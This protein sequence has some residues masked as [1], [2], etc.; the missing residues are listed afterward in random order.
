ML[1]KPSEILVGQRWHYINPA[2]GR[3]FIHTITRIDTNGYWCYSDLNRDFLGGHLIVKELLGHEQGS[4]YWTYLGFS[5]EQNKSN[6]DGCICNKCA[7]FVP[8]AQPNVDGSFTCY[9]CRVGF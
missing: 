3:E 2:Y 8:M 4:K 6:Q 5:S 7:S 1:D 9:S